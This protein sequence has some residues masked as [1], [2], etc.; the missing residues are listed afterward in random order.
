MLF[1]EK[2]YCFCANCSRAVSAG[3]DE[4]I[5]RKKGLVSKAGCCSAFRYDPLKREPSRV[6][7]IDF[8]SYDERDFSL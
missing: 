3:E 2:E 7:P 4:M 5:C 8:S 1:K 6:R